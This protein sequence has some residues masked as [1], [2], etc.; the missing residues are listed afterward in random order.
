MNQAA[1]N[2]GRCCAE[3]SE[4]GFFDTL[5]IETE[6]VYKTCPFCGQGFRVNTPN[7]S[8]MGSSDRA[9]GLATVPYQ[10]CALI[11]CHVSQR[12]LARDK[13]HKANA[14][15]GFCQDIQK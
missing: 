7:N 4:R 6:S 3:T 10:P 15:I 8:F 5:K 1:E 13:I 14:G 2:V 12:N 11:C 9:L